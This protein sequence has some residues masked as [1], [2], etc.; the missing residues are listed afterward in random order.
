MLL[1]FLVIPMCEVFPEQ[2]GE[3]AGV[4]GVIVKDLKE[5][6]RECEVF[7]EFRRKGVR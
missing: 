4:G 2:K 5:A 7:N 6:A 3:S 1:F